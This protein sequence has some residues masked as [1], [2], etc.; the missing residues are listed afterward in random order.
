MM[1]GKGW[2]MGGLG[3]GISVRRFGLGK[4]AL[5]CGV[6]MVLALAPIVQVRAETLADAMALAYDSNPNLRAARA[7]LRA[8]DESVAIAVSGWRPT[9][10]AQGSIQRQDLESVTPGIAA[11]SVNAA[12]GLSSSRL[13]TSKTLA[14]TAN[15]PLFR[16]FKTVA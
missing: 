5:F 1:V 10:S 14:V 6:A 16:G 12:L 8:T 9:I 4:R 7:Q 3:A 13:L 15:Q 2:T 11:G